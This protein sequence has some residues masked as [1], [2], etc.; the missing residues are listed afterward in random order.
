M[1]WTGQWLPA[2]LDRA[3]KL[4]HSVVRDVGDPSVERLFRMNATLCLHRAATPEEVAGL[5]RS[6]VEDRPAL[7][8]GPVEIYWAKGVEHAESCKPCH[9]PTR[10]VIE[11]SRPDLWVPLDCGR[12]P[13]C[14]ARLLCEQACGV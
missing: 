7:A 13:P 9:A 12:C 8:G 2:R 11:P 5:P 3:T 1:L 4:L 10:Y 14:L 6:W